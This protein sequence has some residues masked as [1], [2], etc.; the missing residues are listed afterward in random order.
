VTLHE[1]IE[2]VLRE[3]N[4]P[5]RAKEIASLINSQ[6]Y[7]SRTDREPLQGAQILARVKNYPSVFQNINGYIIV[8]ENESWKNLMTSYWYL[9]NSL[10]G[11]YI[12]SDI[13]FIISVLFFY[14]RLVD[15]NDRPG[16]GYPLKFGIRLESAVDQVLDGGRMMIEELKSLENYNF[17][18]Q[19]IF[20]EC[21]RLIEKLDNYKT[22]EI[23]SIISRVNTKNLDDREFG[24]V[25]D[26]FITLDSLESYK[27]T[28][29]HTPYNLRE[30][31]VEL[32]NPV[33][34]S[35]IYD[36]VAGTGGLLIDAF[37]YEGRSHFYAKG[38][39]VNKRTAQLGN[40]NVLMH[41]IP[42]VEIES[43]DCFEQINDNIHFD[44]II[45]DLPANGITNSV[46]YFMLFNQYKLKAK[47]SKKS[48]GSLILLVLSKL[49]DSG[50][51]VLTVSDGF[52]VK[53]GIEKEIRDVLIDNDIVEAVI[54]LPYGAIG[55]YTEA[56]A[57]LLILNKN[58]PADLINRIKF[59][60]AKKV[61]KDAKSFG[62]NNEEIIQVY[63]SSEI[64][65]KNAQVIS[66][67][68]LRSDNNLSADAYEAEYTLANIMLSEGSGKLLSDLV[69]I[70]S[71]LQPDKM[72]VSNAGGVPFVKIENLSKEILDRNLT[73]KIN[74]R[75]ALKQEYV[76]SIISKD[77]I[78]VARI[79]DNLKSTIFKP[80][81]GVSEIIPHSNVCA[82]I[83]SHGKD[84][85]N[86]EY[87][88]YQLHS[89]FIQEQLRS[90]RLGAV[91][92]YISISALKQI[93][94]PY[95]KLD[96]QAS[97]VESQK[98]NLVAEE[99]TRF[100]ENIKTL[101]YKDEVEQ[102]ESDVVRT[103]THQLRPIFSGLD[104]LVK[105]IKR[106]SDKNNL[107][108]LTEYQEIELD[109][110]DPELAEHTKRPDNYSLNEL[111]QKLGNDSNHL[112]TVLS[113]V[114][115]VMNFKLSF[116]DFEEVN[117]L[118]F[119]SDYKQQKEIDVNNKYSIIVR[120][121]SETAMISK[122]SFK[123]L[124]DQL[125]LN[126][127]THGFKNTSNRKQFRIQ[128]IVKYS[129]QRDVIT[130]EYSNNGRSYKGNQKDFVSAFEKGRDS[131]GSGI[132]G[133]YVNRIVE[134]HDGKIVVA[135]NYEKGFF[136]TIE[137]PKKQNHD[138]E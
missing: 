36:P 131:V 44:Y 114:D 99:R 38:S 113:N 13:Q 5:L 1:A 21:A 116:S 51:A 17:S 16:R 19:G 22:Q 80:A 61:G 112:S 104:S 42:N 28:V 33:A 125:L 98:A 66:Y 4:R 111:L 93:V 50:K 119:L 58:K 126:A 49:S 133:H 27:S 32:L 74:N 89:S 72:D 115:K 20:Y 97:F 25:F 78:L 71:G 130:I 109:N 77:C 69:E 43:R 110:I 91:L 101:D 12:I 117:I 56:K 100:E 15:I 105:R 120:G 92:P 65:S 94:I 41:G 86:L 18:T 55:H 79:G 39:E 23:S 96:A 47:P 9:V 76:R 35:S 48:F 29:N 26:Y 64:I 81:S 134:A 108:N 40:M 118:D 11:I 45:A 83:P 95:M 87:L 14:K 129:K 60:T 103:L 136:L 34:G 85:I 123:E 122:G 67:S 46:E 30:L 90:R 24:N 2:K 132:G 8:I 52:L 53:R 124:L 68:D 73:L 37:Q 63:R 54:S 88:Y 70:K 127:E 7:Y 102:T 62:L 138:Y 107:A 137:L 31:M 128:F 3:H 75:V 135:E 59:I 121:D 57:S 10:K 82:L 6:N 106:I 84:P